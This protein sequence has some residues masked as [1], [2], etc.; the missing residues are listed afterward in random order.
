LYEIEKAREEE[1][2]E[3]KN[4]L[5]RGEGVASSKQNIKS[6]E[7]KVE[8]NLIEFNTNVTTWIRELKN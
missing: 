3:L 2:L 5:T 6:P 1:I 7:T 4:K 8:S